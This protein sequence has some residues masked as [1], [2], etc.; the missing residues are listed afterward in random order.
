MSRV[1]LIGERLAARSPGSSF[2]RVSTAD[3]PDHS[4][5]E[6]FGRTFVA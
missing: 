1:K 4:T 6:A 5:N 2:C 3:R